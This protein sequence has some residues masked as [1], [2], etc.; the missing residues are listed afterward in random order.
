MGAKALCK[1]MKDAPRQCVDAAMLLEQKMQHLTGTK[2]SYDGV[3]QLP[4]R[5]CYLCLGFRCASSPSIWLP[6]FLPTADSISLC[7]V[8]VG[9]KP[10][11]VFIFFSVHYGAQ[12]NV[13]S[14]G[15]Y[16][17]I[18]HPGLLTAQFRSLLFSSLKARS[19]LHGKSIWQECTTLCIG[20]IR[21]ASAFHIAGPGNGCH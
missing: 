11:S 4:E 5:H 17:G 18:Y 16:F 9:S 1:Y 14:E 7:L 3:N 19:L 21:L 8:W 2:L 12:S 13:G 10:S 20:L 6:L 15:S